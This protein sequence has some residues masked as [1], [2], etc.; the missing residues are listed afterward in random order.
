MPATVNLFAGMARSYKRALLLM[1]PSLVTHL[2]SF[3][4]RRKSSPEETGLPPARER[5]IRINLHFPN[6]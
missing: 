2:T 6:G 3:P 1:F 4:R 5:R